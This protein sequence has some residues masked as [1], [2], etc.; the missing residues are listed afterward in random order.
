[1]RFEF[2]GRAHAEKFT[3]K[4]GINLQG[5]KVNKRMADVE[6]KLLESSRVEKFASSRLP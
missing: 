5:C 3:P 1:V 6:E 4:L 2:A